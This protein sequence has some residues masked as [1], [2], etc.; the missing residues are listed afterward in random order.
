[1]VRRALAL[2]TRLHTGLE[3]RMTALRVATFARDD[4][5]C[6]VLCAQSDGWDAFLVGIGTVM[7]IAARAGVGRFALVIRLAQALD[8]RAPGWRWR[9]NG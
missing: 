9:T 7:R 3:D 4:G 5:A 1:M 8:Q 6:A 2:A